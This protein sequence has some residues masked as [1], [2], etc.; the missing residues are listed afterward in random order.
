MFVYK[1]YSEKAGG[2]MPT[3]VETRPIYVYHSIQIRIFNDK[4]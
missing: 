3:R 2:F 4:Q 1:L